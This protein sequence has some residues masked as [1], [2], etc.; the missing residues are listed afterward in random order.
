MKA[1]QEKTVITPT[2]VDGFITQIQNLEESNEKLTAI[3]SEMTAERRR[4]LGERPDKDAD[5]EQRAYELM[6]Q[7]LDKITHQRN[8]AY[9]KINAAVK[10]LVR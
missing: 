9:R 1:T 3:I 8:A 4:Q 6:A 7:L 5:A 10:Q 2:V